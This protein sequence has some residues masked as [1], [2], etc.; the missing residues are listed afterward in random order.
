MKLIEIDKIDIPEWGWKE[1]DA[2]VSAR[3]LASLRRYG[4]I[5]SILVRETEDRYEIVDGRHVLEGLQQL[6]RKQVWAHSLG[7][8]SQAEAIKRALALGIQND[9]NYARLAKHIGDLRG[10][11]DFGSLPSLTPYTKERIDYFSKL[12]DFDWSEYD[13][14]GQGS[15]LDEDSEFTEFL[16]AEEDKQE[17]E[18]EKKPEPPKP[19]PKPKPK[20]S[21]PTIDRSAL[22]SAVRSTMAKES[23]REEPKV[24]V[25]DRGSLRSNLSLFR[26]KPPTKPKTS[27]PAPVSA[28]KIKRVEMGRPALNIAA[29][30]DWRPEAPPDLSRYTE[31]E[32]DCETTG[33][34]WWAG[35]KAVGYAI[36]YGDKEQYLPIRHNGGG[37]LDEATVHRWM[38]RELRGK[39]ITNANSRY[40]NHIIYNEGVDL[41]AQDCIWADV[42]H[43]A[44]LL[45]EYRREYDLESLSQEELG[46]GKVE[47][48]LDKNHMG[49]YHAGQV[50]EY[51][52]KDVWLVNQLK[53]K[54]I[55]KLTEQNLD[56]VKKLEC[57]LIYVVCEMER[58]AAYIDVTALQDAVT[59]SATLLQETLFEVSKQCGFTMQPKK[60]ADWVRLFQVLNLPVPGYTD[61]GAPSFKEELLRD[62]DNETVRLARRASKLASLRS[63]FL[64]PY[65]ELVTED[66]KLLFALH[67][68]KSTGYGTVSGRFSMSGASKAIG[69]FGANLQQVERVNT[70]R[71]AFGYKHDD[72]SHDDEIFL[73]R[74][75]FI[76][77]NGLFL[78]ADAQS[79]EY[80]IAAHFSESRQ[81]LKAYES[82]WEKLKRGELTGKWIDFHNT[83][84]G[85]IRPYK[86]LSRNVIKNTNFLKIYGGGREK[87]AK[88]LGL[89]RN[90]SD[91]IID[92]Y[93]KM[94]PEFATL[95]KKAGRIAKRRGFVR[96]I[97]GRR[98]RFEGARGQFTHAALNRVIQGSAAD[99]LKVK[100]VE[101]HKERKYTGFVMRYPVHD[102]F[103]GDATGGEETVRRVREVLNRQSFNLKVPIVWEVDSGKNWAE[104][105]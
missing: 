26:D 20:E 81:L 98:A 45:D 8:V 18:P 65:A 35:D 88:T 13:D 62:V 95:L 3:V 29:N 101:L 39:L 77:Q 9:I 90:E 78:S 19:K 37:N 5:Q 15:L 99:V 7:K 2:D 30:S 87:A 105:H 38:E 103:D 33:L 43:Y 56:R 93:D 55:P 16:G 42:Q 92:V 97:M 70:Q 34:R 91:Q 69:Q 40:D 14:V 104:A 57:D 23:P 94:F 80:R 59:K 63:K 47:S 46:E 21:A 64:T 61:K 17:E 10:D 84:G 48:G 51:A 53:K 11:K 79:I 102:E 27:T 74:A 22:R 28:P 41:E 49:E 25:L 54:Y 68:L 6:R 66:S 72:S 71:E 86:D 96:T 12:L 100:A 73:V 50:A 44:A 24:N 83:V 60:N 4:Q 82:D 76:A 58:N 36:K 52:C 89:P 31:I 85:I 75:L 67:Q 1:T 32:L